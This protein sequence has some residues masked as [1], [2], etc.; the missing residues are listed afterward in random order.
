MIDYYKGQTTDGQSLAELAPLRGKLHPK[1]SADDNFKVLN[2]LQEELEHRENF[3]QLR[4]IDRQTL[5]HIQEAKHFFV[6]FIAKEDYEQTLQSIYAEKTMANS[7]VEDPMPD[8][9]TDQ[10]L[11]L[12]GLL[13]GSLASIFLLVMTFV[14]HANLILLLV[15]GLVA[16]ILFLLYANEEDA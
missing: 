1:Y 10:A 2:Q 12:R 7:I 8:R 13:W 11:H 3:G 9:K 6:D 14:F 16:L 5:K 15:I 4:D